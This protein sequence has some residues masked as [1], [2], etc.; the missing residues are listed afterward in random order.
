MGKYNF[1]RVGYIKSD[2]KRKEVP[3]LRRLMKFRSPTESTYDGG[4]ITSYYYNIILL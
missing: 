4:P 2:R 3:V 1:L